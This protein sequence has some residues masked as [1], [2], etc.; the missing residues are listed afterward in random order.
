M[1]RQARFGGPMKSC[2]SLRGRSRRIYSCA[3]AAGSLSPTE[4]RS[5]TESVHR[6]RS[7]AP[8]SRNSNRVGVFS[9]YYCCWEL[10]QTNARTN[11]A[12][13][14][15]SQASRN[16]MDKGSL[17]EAM[18]GTQMI[19]CDMGFTGHPGGT[20]PITISPRSWSLTAF[21]ASS[22][23]PSATLDRGKARLIVPALTHTPVS[24]TMVS[25]L[26]ALWPG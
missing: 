7:D 3:R 4:R 19:F 21:P 18:R 8:C 23:L 9:T 15:Y 2:P 25:N 11:R 6:G 16:S 17:Q 5:R 24:F 26:Q 22:L 10:E 20:Q 12:N 13:P 1:D 14:S